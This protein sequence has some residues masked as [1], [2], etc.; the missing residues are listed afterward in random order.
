MNQLLHRA[1]R[2]VRYEYLRRFENPA[3]LKTRQGIFKVPIGV[4]DPISRHL[5]IEGHFELDLIADAMALIRNLKGRA[6]GQGTL[7][8]IGANNG[9]ISIGM[10]VTGELDAAVAIEPEPTNFGRL[11]E[12]LA[13]NGLGSRVHSIHTALSD[14]PSS[15]TFELSESNWGDHRV[16][17]SSDTPG[18]VRDIFNESKRPTMSVP[19][20]TLN[21][22]V[23]DLPAR[24]KQ[25]VAVVWIDVQGYEGYVF[26]GGREFLSEGVP[27]VSE[28]WPYGIARTGMTL[29]D[30][31]AIVRNTWRSFWVQ[32]RGRFVQY[33]VLAFGSFLD[34]L[35]LDGYAENV[36]F[37]RE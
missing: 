31:D 29:D 30:F 1:I 15:L 23:A 13:L 26:A 20:V 21:N 22:L 7:V 33:P 16:R 14:R 34:E 36:I 12:N 25:D 17:R 27:V 4:A 35:G 8:D 18:Q 3:T 2:R 28:V 37:T 9:V 24:F 10:L 32:R 19:A 6:K 11:Q 5:F